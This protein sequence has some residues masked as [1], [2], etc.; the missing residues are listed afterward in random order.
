MQ[1]EQIKQQIADLETIIDGEA[2]AF[3]ARHPAHFASKEKEEVTGSHSIGKSEETVGEHRKEEVSVVEPVAANEI[4][5]TNPVQEE[6]KVEE[7]V[8]AE[9]ESE[10]S[11]P[12]PEKTAELDKE[13]SVQLEKDKEEAAKDQEEHNGEVV[14]ENEEDTVIY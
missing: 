5:T 2:A 14:M 4:D 8:K 6:P 12:A 11:A 9:Q 3:R 13:E 10:E 7:D 1:K